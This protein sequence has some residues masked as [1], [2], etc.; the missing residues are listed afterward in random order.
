MTFFDF[1]RDDLRYNRQ[2]KLSPFQERR[3]S[4]EGFT[5]FGL[6][7]V[8]GLFS[9]LFIVIRPPFNQPFLC[10]SISVI[11]FMIFGLINYK[12]LMRPV[13]ESVVQSKIG[14][15]GKPPHPTL[16]PVFYIGSESFSAKD[17]PFTVLE[18][19]VPYKIY[20]TPARHAILSIEILS[21]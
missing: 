14:T 18:W 2:G 11:T 15:L 1:N 17:D 20:Y 4:A 6:L 13:E 21:S 10:S 3:F 19:N 16:K 7:F 5:A 8:V 12:I 9:I